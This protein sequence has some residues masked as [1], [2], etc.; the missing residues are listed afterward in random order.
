MKRRNVVFGT[1]IV[2]LCAVVAGISL[3]G[4][5]RKALA[6]AEVPASTDRVQIYGILD[7][8]S[9]NPIKGHSIVAFK[10]REE[11]TNEVMNVLYENTHVA[12][13]YNFPAAS[14]AKVTGYYDATANPPRLVASE[15]STKCPSKYDQQMTLNQA[16]LKA[17]AEWQKDLPQG[18]A[19]TP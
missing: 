2:A 16:Q 7:H 19:P 9:I 17:Q 3:G 10:L 6:F 5:T 18:Q 8:A 11:K 15:V 1:G 14:H 12:L 4:S 13:P